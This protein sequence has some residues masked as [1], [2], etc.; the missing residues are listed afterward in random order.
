VLNLIEKYSYLPRPGNAE[1]WK[2]R[3]SKVRIQVMLQAFF[4]EKCTFVLELSC[5][6]IMQQSLRGLSCAANQS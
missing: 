2:T 4:V 5:L 6:K 1:V 3:K